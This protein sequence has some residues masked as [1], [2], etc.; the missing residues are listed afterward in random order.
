M[1]IL[2]VTDRFFPVAEGS[3]DVAGCLVREP[4]WHGHERLIHS[5]DFRLEQSNIDSLPD[6]KVSAA[7]NFLSFGG[8][9]RL[10]P[11]LLSSSINK[12]AVTGIGPSV[13]K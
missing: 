10:M 9:P 13:K 5:T 4:P 3:A 6:V 8:K 7:R 12:H 2:Q 1:K 11:G